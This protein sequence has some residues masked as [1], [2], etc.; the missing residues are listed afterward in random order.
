MPTRVEKGRSRVGITRHVSV[1]VHI[2]S[3]AEIYAYPC[4]TLN[5][6]TDGENAFVDTRDD[7]AD[8]GL[9][10]SLFAEV[11]DVFATF[12]DNDA[13]VLGANERAESQDLL[14]RDRRRTRTAI[15]RL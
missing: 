8:T 3:I 13:G 5:I 12:P 14:S 4:N 1:T 6:T 11:G 10:A 2:A 7:L 15:A 9:D